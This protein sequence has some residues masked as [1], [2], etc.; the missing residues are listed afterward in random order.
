MMGSFDFPN[1]VGLEK[2]DTVF[3]RSDWEG[4]IFEIM[5]CMGTFGISK[6]PLAEFEFD[7]LFSLWMPI[8]QLKG[9]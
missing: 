9:L 2:L 3:F 7:F 4:G 1:V 8:L 5:R 6:I